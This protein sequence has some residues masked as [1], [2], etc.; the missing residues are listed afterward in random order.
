MNNNEKLF[1]RIL[2]EFSFPNSDNNEEHFEM[3]ECVE[4]RHVPNEQDDEKQSACLVESYLGSNMLATP[5]YS[6]LHTKQPYN[7]TVL[8]GEYDDMTEAYEAYKTA[9]SY[10]YENIRIV[11]RNDIEIVD[12]WGRERIV[13]PNGKVHYEWDH[14]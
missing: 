8:F 1:E 9:L 3:I 6:V 14:F 7:E 5:P 11:D 2:N 4:H 13:E 12:G 10:N